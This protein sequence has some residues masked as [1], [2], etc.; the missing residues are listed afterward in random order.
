M[1]CENQKKFEII[2]KLDCLLFM[3]SDNTCI[4]GFFQPFR[5]FSAFFR[6]TLAEIFT[7]KE[8]ISRSKL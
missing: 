8:L 4:I 6:K 7:P 2:I 5:L 3:T 1:K